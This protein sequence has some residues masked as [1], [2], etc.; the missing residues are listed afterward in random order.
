MKRAVAG[1]AAL[2]GLG[3]CGDPAPAPGASE[4]RYAD[5]WLAF[6][7]SAPNDHYAAVNL[8]ETEAGWAGR[9]VKTDGEA[10]PLRNIR[11]TATALSFTVPALGISYDAASLG[12]GG[13]AGEWIDPG[14]HGNA[15]SM[16]LASSNSPPAI[17]G[18]LVMLADGRRMHIACTGEGAPAVLLDYGAG[19]SMKKDWGDIADAIAAKAGTRVCLYDRAGRGL[20]DPAPMPRDADT[21]VRDIESMMTAANISAPY[22]LI[23]HSLGSYHVRQYANTYPEKVAGMVLVDPSGDGQLERFYAVIPKMKQLNES[24]FMAQANLNCVS[25]LREAPAP[26]DDPFAQQCGGNDADV[27]EA[28]RSEI[29]QM[30]G[31]STEQLVASR[32]SYGDMPLIVLTRTDYDRDMPPAF[33]QEDKAAMRGL[34]ETM[35]AEMAALSSSGEQRFIPGAGHYIQRDAPQ[36]VVDAASQVVAAARNASTTR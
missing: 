29:E 1:L 7:G 15:P 33:T 6:A 3:A 23:G 22:V 27:I 25:R 14:P 36:A 18:E 10:F 13:W 19:G 34:W 11:R 16:T 4:A 32:R 8:H 28:T 26:P 20:S 30:A 12:D 2:L 24:T 21:V 35:H 31:A 5:E 17:A 9:L